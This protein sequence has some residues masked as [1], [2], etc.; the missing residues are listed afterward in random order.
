MARPA[1]L[2][3][4]GF[5]QVND[6]LGHPA[7]DRVLVE[8]AGALRAAVRAGDLPARLGGDEFAVLLADVRDEREAVAVA[9]RIIAGIVAR[10]ASSGCPVRVGASA[11]VVVRT[12]GL[13]DETMFRLADAALYRSKA[14]GKGRVEL[15]V[16]A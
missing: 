16:A 9:D 15:H 2:D 3:L 8:A 1:R 6:T 7:G 4:D 10:V 12:P 11:G 5:K 14:A 13:D